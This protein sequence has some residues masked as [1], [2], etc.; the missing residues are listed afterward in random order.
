MGRL[1]ERLKRRQ[2]ILILDTVALL[3]IGIMIGLCVG[4]YITEIKF[5]D[6]AV[7]AGVGYFKN[8]VFYFG[9]N[10]GK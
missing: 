5:Q 9:V 10:N 7:E 8:E 4:C 3:L 6:K 2:L 1:R